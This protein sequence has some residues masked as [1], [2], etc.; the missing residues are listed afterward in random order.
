VGPA[1]GQLVEALVVLHAQ[2]HVADL[3]LETGFVPYL[4]AKKTK[5]ENPGFP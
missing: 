2:C 4:E 1:V 3:T 5:T